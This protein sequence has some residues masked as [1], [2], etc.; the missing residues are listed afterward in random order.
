M[1]IR[2]GAAVGAHGYGA[3]ERDKKLG[4]GWLSLPSTD[5]AKI[6]NRKKE[7]RE[8][9]VLRAKRVPPVYANM[10]AERSVVDFN[11]LQVEINTGSPSRQKILT[12]CCSELH[13]AGL[14]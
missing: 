11:N 2:E 1:S 12:G 4:S 9:F 14:R 8:C 3:N 10:S 13:D 7:D 5:Y 6:R